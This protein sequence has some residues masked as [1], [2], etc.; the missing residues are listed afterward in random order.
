MLWILI[1]FKYAIMFLSSPIDILTIFFT[2]PN[3]NC[4]KKILT[5]STLLHHNLTSERPLMTSHVFWPFLTYLP[6]LSYSITSDFGGYLGPPLPTLI[7]DVINGCSPSEKNELHII[8]Q[9]DILIKEKKSIWKMWNEISFLNPR[10]N[11]NNIKKYD[12][13]C[14]TLF[15]MQEDSST[16]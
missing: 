8:L 4:I 12:A 6:T 15:G 2:L 9:E 11:D 5:S 14:T 13:F 1:T 7:S 16:V 3:N 10:N